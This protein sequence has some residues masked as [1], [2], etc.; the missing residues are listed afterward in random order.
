MEGRA[1][2]VVLEQSRAMVARVL[3]KSMILRYEMVF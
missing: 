3:D 1:R 2:I